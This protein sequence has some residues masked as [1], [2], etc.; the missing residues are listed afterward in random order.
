MLTINMLLVFIIIIEMYIITLLYFIFK[1]KIEELIIN[2][3]WE[4]NTKRNYIKLYKSIKRENKTLRF[5]NNN[6]RKEIR[7]L[8]WFRKFIKQVWK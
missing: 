8:R 6:M 2:H 4:I 1:D 3:K 7:K 5:Y